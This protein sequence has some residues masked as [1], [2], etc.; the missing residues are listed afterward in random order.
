MAK[1]SKYI[2]THKKGERSE[3][4]T[5]GV[6]SVNQVMHTFYYYLDGR[7][8]N[9]NG[10][11]LHGTFC[12]DEY[13]LNGIRLSLKKYKKDVKRLRKIMQ[14]DCKLRFEKRRRS[15]G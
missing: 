15:N 7:L 3:Q 4:L 12:G 10:P 1:K 11:A 13:Y 2:R 9:E 14:K 6:V 8:H 5:P